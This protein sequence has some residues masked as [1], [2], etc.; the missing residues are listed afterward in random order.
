M[1]IK[2]RSEIHNLRKTQIDDEMTSPN[3]PIG[4]ADFI[5]LFTAEEWRDS[6]K[7]SNLPKFTQQAGVE[8]SS[9]WV[10]PKPLLTVVGSHSVS[11]EE[12]NAS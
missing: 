5:L 1:I 7:L 4:V 11:N 10:A 3:N 8:P 9:V 12:T 6:G 2:A